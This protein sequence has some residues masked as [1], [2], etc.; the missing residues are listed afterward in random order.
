[1]LT[2]VPFVGDIMDFGRV[3]TAWLHMPRTQSKR[4]NAKTVCPSQAYSP[5]FADLHFTN[6]PVVSNLRV[7]S[8]SRNCHI[9]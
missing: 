7:S 5:T 3:R 9:S 4:F 8:E 2:A 6:C 1:M